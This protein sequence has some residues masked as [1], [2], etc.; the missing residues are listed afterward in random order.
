MLK[1][2]DKHSPPDKLPLEF[3]NITLFYSTRVKKQV[4]QTKA[5]I[6]DF[7]G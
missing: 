6:K 2:E 4:F 7:Y 5:C 3:E 1:T